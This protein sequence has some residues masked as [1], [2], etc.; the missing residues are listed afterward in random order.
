MKVSTKTNLKGVQDGAEF[1]IDMGTWDALIIRNTKYD[2]K[3]DEDVFTDKYRVTYRYPKYADGEII[4]GEFN[5][6]TRIETLSAAVR[7]F[8][9]QHV[10]CV[11]NITTDDEHYS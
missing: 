10:I 1:M 11:T 3:T 7:Y 5:E 2:P 4:L 6:I 9:R 8:N